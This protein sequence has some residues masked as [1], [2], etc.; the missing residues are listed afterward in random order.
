MYSVEING[1]VTA[2]GTGVAY[3]CVETWLWHFGILV[4]MW[5]PN[6]AT[7]QWINCEQLKALLISTR[8]YTSWPLYWASMWLQMG[9]CVQIPPNLATVQSMNCEQLSALVI[10]TRNYTVIVN[11]NSSITAEHVTLAIDLGLPVQ[12]HFWKHSYA[13]KAN[14]FC[15]ACNCVSP[16]NFFYETP[17][18]SKIFLN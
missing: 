7:V 13:V 12:W 4:K 6:L 15:T 2:V 9:M 18:L 11:S 14:T 10:S 3:R 5:H 16:I 8:S 1:H 17:E